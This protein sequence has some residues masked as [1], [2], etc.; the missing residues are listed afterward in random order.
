VGLGAAAKLNAACQIVED[1]M[2]LMSF[3]TA[4]NRS[5]GVFQ[6]DNVVDV[7]AVLGS[8]HPD[9]RSVVAADAYI[10]VREAARA[11]PRVPVADIEWLPP[12]ENPAKILCIGLNYEDH[13]RET[14]RQESRHPAIFTRVA[15]SQIGHRADLLR[16]RVSQDLDYEGELAIVIGRGGRYIDRDSA[17][18]HV[19]GYS[20]YDD[21][22]LR[23][24]QRHTHQFTPGKNFPGTGSFG[25]FLVTRDEIPDYRTLHLTTRVNGHL[26]QS[27]GL[28]QL[29]FPIPELIAYCSSFTP[30]SPGDVI[31]T[32]TPGGVG[33]KRNPQLFLKPGDLVEVEI[34]GVGKLINGVA[35]EE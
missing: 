17:M 16:P 29:I 15:D 24:W 12:I 7:G 5:W 31:A 22:T 3:R 6:D 19:A 18:D 32:G 30:L 13:R 21:A 20:C 11:A 35:Q 27:A 26:V 23:D 34:T 28:D 8:T 2:K 4:T 25:P 33:F 9:L 10:E 1:S 14:G